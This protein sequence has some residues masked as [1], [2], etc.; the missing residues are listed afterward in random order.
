MRS[1]NLHEETHVWLL[2]EKLLVISGHEF[3]RGEITDG[4]DAGYNECR[5]LHA[6]YRVIQNCTA[7]SQELILQLK[8]RNNE[9]QRVELI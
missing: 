8:I 7:I 6:I 9:T 5:R 3:T 1:M 2:E 4:G